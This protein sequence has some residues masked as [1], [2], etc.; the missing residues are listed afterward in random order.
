VQEIVRNV[1]FYFLKKNSVGGDRGRSLLCGVVVGG[2][3]VQAEAHHIRL[4]R[5]CNSLQ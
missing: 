2:G 3:W 5:R 4:S 1:G